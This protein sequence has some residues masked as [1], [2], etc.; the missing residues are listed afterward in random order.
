[1]RQLGRADLHDDIVAFPAR[2]FAAAAVLY[3]ALVSARDG[4][5]AGAVSAPAATAL[6][7]ATRALWDLHLA[8]TA[9]PLWREWYL[10]LRQRIF[11][12]PPNPELA[13]RVRRLAEARAGRK[14]DR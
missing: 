7:E 2:L 13:L 6:V 14:G 3:R 1:M 5:H 12:T 8:G 4:R 10:P 11:G 9:Q